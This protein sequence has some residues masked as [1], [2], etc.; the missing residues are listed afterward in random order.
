MKSF[1]RI[2]FLHRTGL[3][4]FHVIVLHDWNIFCVRISYRCQ[5]SEF[6]DLL[7]KLCGLRNA[8]CALIWFRL[9]PRSG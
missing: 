2:L 3:N 8:I 1:R 6:C 4:P 5:R 9:T 7:G